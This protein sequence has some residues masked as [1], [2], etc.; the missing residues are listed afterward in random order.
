MG[1]LLHELLQLG[2]ENPA[3]A[4]QQDGADRPLARRV[5]QPKDYLGERAG[6]E[7]TLAAGGEAGFKVHI[8]PVGLNATGYR[9]FVFYR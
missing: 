1:Q 8:D 3:N 9:L 7:A 2:H 5:L 4:G 6:R